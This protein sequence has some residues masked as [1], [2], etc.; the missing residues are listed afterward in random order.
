MSDRAWSPAERSAAPASHAILDTPCGAEFDDLVQLA[1]RLLD[2]PIALVNLVDEHRQW[3][4]AEVGLGVRET[5][6]SDSFCVHTL[7]QDELL[8][9]EDATCDPRFAA[10]PQVTGPPYIRAYAGVILRGEGGV[11]LGALC[12]LDCKPRSFSEDQVE[13]L[14][15]LGRQ[16]VSHLAL[17]RALHL[18]RTD[19]EQDRATRARLEISEHT[20]GLATEAAGVGAWDLDLIDDVLTWSKTTR[21]TF[22]TT[23]DKARNLADFF[24]RLHPDDVEPVRT[25]MVATLDPAR[26]IPFNVEYRALGED[27]ITRWVEARGQGVFDEAGRCLRAVG[28][29]VDITARKYA[30]TLRIALTELTERLRNI[31]DTADL[32][33]AAAELIGRTLGVSRVGYGAMDTRAETFTV[34]RDWNAPGIQTL[35]GVL[36]FRDYGSYI[37]NLKRGENVVFEDAYLDPRTVDTA[38]R[39]K[40]ISAVAAVNMPVTE[41][42][43]TVAMLYLNHAEPRAFPPHELAFIQE[44]AER[45]RI[46]VERRRAEHDLRRSEAHLRRLNETLEQRVCERTA[47]LE[48]AQEAL[49]QSQKME[50]VGQL[51]GG[52]AHDFNNLL[53]G[54]TGSLELLQSRLAQG[55]FDT[56][57]RYVNAAQGAAR[58]AASLTQ[59]LLAF[60]RRQTLDPKPT[61]V[62]RLVTGMEELIR[63]TVGPS[64]EIEVVGATGL[65]P[66]LIDP[67][68]LENALLNLCINAR[69]A[70]PEGGRLTIETGNKWM[71]ER[72]AQE[73]DLDPGQYVSLCVTDT[74]TGMTPEVIARAFDPFFTTKPLGEGTG[75]GLSMI[76]G[77]VRQSGGQVRVYS[78]VGEGTTMCLYLPRHQG[79]GEEADAKATA[80]ERSAHARAGETVLVVDDEPTVRMLVVEVLEEAGYTAIEATD[81]A[82][83]LKVLQSKRR[84]DLLVTDVGLPGGMNGRQLADAAR[85]GRADLKVLFITGYAENAVVGNGHLDPGMSVLTKPFT[86]DSLARRIREL[87]EG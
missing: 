70:M 45:T 61:N 51:T 16:V 27:R 60:S 38:D 3:F 25:A 1:S 86:I 36:Q 78:E 6:L 44:V 39:L 26:R 41:Q 52:L 71:D 58:R 32:S 17:R 50:A 49:R 5:P 64:I 84:I 69:D 23:V 2:M 66:T 13:V 82:G 75:L 35:A 18:K 37:E 15:A 80:E 63:R 54:I 72:I 20:L 34:E 12:T 7:K 77:F 4:K 85:I 57:D 42:G 28:L 19:D 73:R 33:F 24:S 21:A 22:G 65:W 29:V 79:D 9:V 11:P 83:G 81:G 31:G 59:R 76:Y 30:D 68:Q 53:T 87:V 47:E 67:G 14:R 43:D 74:G 55:R 48:K 46:A 8:L 62:N 40:A 10:N 56:V